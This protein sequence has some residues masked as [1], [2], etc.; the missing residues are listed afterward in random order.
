MWD[1]R[2]ERGEGP[3]RHRTPD[4]W[5][6]ER[7]MRT[8]EEAVREKE[9]DLL[10]PALRQEKH[11]MKREAK[12]EERPKRNPQGSD[13]S[14]G[15]NMGISSVSRTYML[16][17]SRRYSFDEDRGLGRADGIMLQPHVPAYVPTYVP[18]AHSYIPQYIP[19]SLPH[20]VLSLDADMGGSG[21]G[22]HV[23]YQSTCSQMEEE[24]PASPAVK[25]MAVEGYESPAGQ[26]PVPNEPMHVDEIV[27][28]DELPG[29]VREDLE[30]MERA[31][32]KARQ[33]AKAN[34]VGSASSSTSSGSTEE[35]STEEEVPRGP[36]PTA[37]QRP[38]FRFPQTPWRMDPSQIPTSYPRQL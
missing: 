7:D 14:D 15:E 32:R 10:S 1:Y 12:R 6:A 8:E 17:R 3:A 25:D 13:G 36:I 37:A 30:G 5:V 11:D 16:P 31:K 28:C 20:P 29:W 35:G 38:P 9:R 19:L 23:E 24:N 27:I 33:R 2:N 22:Q 4:T 18:I 21:A 34:F 26:F